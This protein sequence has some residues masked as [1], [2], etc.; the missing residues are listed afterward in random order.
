[1]LPVAL[2]ALVLSVCGGG[3]SGT[4]ACPRPHHRDA[5]A[6]STPVP[7]NPPSG[8]LCRLPQGDPAAKCNTQTPDFQSNVNEAIETLRG[9]RPDIFSGDRV[10]NV[11]AYFVGVI[12]VLD[13]QGLCAHT[14]EG[15]ELGV[16]RTNDYSEQ[17]DI[18]SAQNTVRRW[19]AGTCSPAVFPGA[20][21]APH[22]PPPGCTLPPS[23]FIACGRPGEG[24]FYQDVT[25]AIDQVMRDRPS[26]FDSPTR[27]RRDGRESGPAGVPEQ[28][29]E[30]P[31]AGLLR[32]LRRRRDHDEAH[33][34]VH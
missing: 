30:H 23:H 22:T 20:E 11:G 21:P 18:L 6:D 31:W 3:E 13:R 33:Q 26:L 4:E 16:K 25:A 12:K 28:R 14:E 7:T 10:L 34:R 2:S 29:H 15:E 5:G 27:R 32:H 17:Y 19:Y 8:I 9:E 24:Q 1:V